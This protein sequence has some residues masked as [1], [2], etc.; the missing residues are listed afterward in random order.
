VK[1][2]GNC[3]QTLDPTARFCPKCG[4]QLVLDTHRNTGP[5]RHG[6]WF[7]TLIVLGVF[8][9][10]GIIGQK[11]QDSA[12]KPRS[13]EEQAKEQRDTRNIRLAAD[14][15]K[16]LRRAMRNP[17]AF[18]LSEVLIMKDDAVCYTYRA[19]N[20]FGGMNEGRAVMA[21]DG[22][23]EASENSSK[24]RA[25]WNRECAR[26]TGLVWTTAV[27]DAADIPSTPSGK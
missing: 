24:F 9:A 12:T 13:P 8:M 14:G 15:A 27:A 7:Y 18:R 6:F 1:I 4:A 3:G 16:V 25:L 19:Q 21:P 10:I 22:R 17:D 23:F 11:I 5:K 20:G 2:C 26:K